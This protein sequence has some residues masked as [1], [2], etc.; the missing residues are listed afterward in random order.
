MSGFNPVQSLLA[1]VRTWRNLRRY[2]RKKRRLLEI[3]PGAQR[4]PGFET[5]NIAFSGD[6]DYVG[7]AARPLPFRDG[8]FEVVYASH[9]LEHIPWYQTVDA[10]REWARI[11]QP[12]GRLEIW[13]PDGEKICRAFLEGES[14]GRSPLI[15]DAWPKFNPNH[16]PC[17]WVAGRLFTYGDGT[18]RLDHP[19]WHRAIFTERLLKQALVQAG[20]RDPVRLTSKDVRGYDHG[21]I[22]LGVRAFR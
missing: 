22:N 16:D 19:N 20:L 5:L 9:I 1:R 6:V 11:L 15:D 7:D 21:W 10:L 4:I 8:E 3:G 14:G 13:V 2:R 12:G 17:L 18:G